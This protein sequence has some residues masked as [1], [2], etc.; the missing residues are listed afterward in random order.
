MIRPSSINRACEECKRK[1]TRCDGHRPACGLC[2]RAGFTCA[3]PRRK[4]REQGSQRKT[5][6]AREALPSNRSGEVADLNQRRRDPS[7]AECAQL[8]PNR[9]DSDTG[10]DDNEDTIMVQAPALLSDAES[11]QWLLAD[12]DMFSYL[13]TAVPDIWTVHDVS[14]FDPSMLEHSRAHLARRRR[15][16]SAFLPL[17]HR[18]TFY[19]NYVDDELGTKSENLSEDLAIILYAMM[20]LSARYHPCPYY[21]DAPSKDRGVRFA[22]RAQAIYDERSN[23]NRQEPKSLRWLQGCILLSFYNQAC[24]P[25]GGGD[26]E[27]QYC[28]RYAYQLG[29][30]KLDKPQPNQPQLAETDAEQWIRQEEQRCTWWSIWELDCFN[31]VTDRCPLRIG[32]K[33]MHVFLPVSDTA[34]FNGSPMDSSLFSADVMLTWKCLRDGPNRDEYAWFLI[35]NYI[36]I[37][38]H[39][40][41]QQRTSSWESIYILEMVLSSFALLF[42][43]VFSGSTGR[44][45]FSE[46]TYARNNWLTFTRLSI[47]SARTIIALLREHMSADPIFTASNRFLDHRGAVTWPKMGP[48]NVMADPYRPI[49]HE[50]SH[51]FQN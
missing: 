38:A 1:K 6:N 13:S 17:F 15:L 26:S 33:N 27:I 49:M 16:G 36:L 45:A 46:S 23:A 24:K 48:V 28:V 4:P 19:Q 2:S 7:R 21:G 37:K 32:R 51:L 11:T 5:Q 31:A 12:Q 30:H 9:A 40:L 25:K 14:A 22:E 10:D 8:T 50:V 29:L 3:Y 18:P 43:E 47:Q 44:L 35:G 34:W 20:A 41:G 39:E 42:Y